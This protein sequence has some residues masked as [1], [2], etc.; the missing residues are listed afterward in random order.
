LSEVHEIN[1]KKAKNEIENIYNKMSSV[2]SHNDRMIFMR[3]KLYVKFKDK[4]IV[5]IFFAKFSVHK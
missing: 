1:I 3:K 4:N 5:V 2:K